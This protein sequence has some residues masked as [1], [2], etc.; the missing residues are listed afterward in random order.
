MKSLTYEDII[1]DALE[2]AKIRFKESKPMGN[3][4]KIVGKGASGDSTLLL[5]KMVEDEILAF[6]NEK[7]GRCFIIS[8]E[9]GLVGEQSSELT[10]LVD[11]VDGSTNASH[12]IP[13]FS[14]SIAIAKG[15]RFSDI[16][17]AGTID[18]VSGELITATKGGGCRIDGR[19]AQPSKVD[20]LSKAVVSLSL[21]VKGEY[22]NDPT[23]LANLINNI[24][25]PR[26]L[27]TAA[28]ETAYVAIGRVDGFIEPYPRLRTYDCLPSLFLV[29]EAKGAY[30]I[31]QQKP[32]DIDLRT[33]ETVSYAAAGCISLLEKIMKLI[34]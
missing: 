29:K 19:E 30:K 31:L 18:L 26:I 12:G 9:A 8:E 33:K 7:I 1:V 27:G 4:S 14:S 5:D 15:R 23:M 24:R 10:V 6:L 34:V 21:R 20:D 3:I 17:A 2:H 16:E 28:L 13:L 22:R 25:H 11:P 32:Q